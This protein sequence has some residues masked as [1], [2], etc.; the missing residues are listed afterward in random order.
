MTTNNHAS[1]SAFERALNNFK[2]SLKPKYQT[3][4]QHATVDS[5]KQCIGN[6]Q[7]IQH[8]SR[9]MQNLTRLQPFIEAMEQYG[10]V[11]TIFANTNAIIAYVWVASVMVEAFEELLQTY[12][13]IGDLIPLLLQYEQLFRKHPHMVRILVLMYE[14]ILSFHHIALRYFQQPLWRQMFDATWKTHKSKF[15]GIFSNMSHHRGLIESQA[16]IA[17]IE[18]IQQ[19]RERDNDRLETQLLHEENQR[20]KAVYG[21]LNAANVDNDQYHF[22]QL[23]AEH[24]G[25]GR[26]LLDHPSFKDDWFNPQYPKV[27]PL[28]WL[29]GIPGAGKTVLASL[30]VEE[31]QKLSPAPTVAF[32]YCKHGN[33][34]RDNFLWMARSILAQLLKQHPVMLEYFFQKCC[35][36]PKPILDSLVLVEELLAFA[37]ENCSSAYVI[38][39]GLDECPRDERKHIVKWFRKL[40]EDPV[41]EPD[42]IRCLFISQDDGVARKD[43]GGLS[44]TKITTQDNRKDIEQYCR[45]KAEELKQT[46]VGLSDNKA[47][48]IADRVLSSTHGMFLFAKLV[49]LNLLSQT[50]LCGLEEE[51]DP[52]RFPEGINDA[53][54]RIVFRI[55]EQS[56]GPRLTDI[57]KLL[58]WLACAKRSLKWYEIQGMKAINVSKR[59]IDHEGR[60]FRVDPTDLCASLV[61]S[62]PDGSLEF[63]H[64]TAKFFLAE[65]GYVDVPKAELQIANLCIDYLNLPALVDDPN[66]EGVHNGDYGFV[67]YATLYWVRHLEAGLSHSKNDPDAIADLAESLEIFLD[68]HWT[69]RT[70]KIAIGK[71]NSDR[72]KVFAPYQFYKRLE[73]A[74]VSA[75]RQLTF[76]GK[77]RKEEIVLDL[78][79]VVGRVRKELEALIS[80]SLDQEVWTDLTLKYGS[81]L[82]KCPR[83][84]CQSFSSGFPTREERERHVAKHDLPFNC[85][86]RACPRF[87][88]G[89]AKKIECDKHVQEVHSAP[90]G[91]D[92]QFPTNDEVAESLQPPKAPEPIPEPASD[93][94]QDPEPDQTPQTVSIPP[95]SRKKPKTRE[96]RC[97]YCQKL[98]TK[99]WNLDSHR[100]THTKDRPYK[101]DVCPQDFPRKSDYRR[102]ML[103]H[104]ENQY[105]CGG[106]LRNGTPWGCGYSFPRADNLSNHYKSQTGKLCYAPYA[107]ELNSTPSRGLAE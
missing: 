59:V 60:R 63:V 76:F 14:D 41:N 69:G 39:D 101:C 20:F 72:L 26:W 21:W 46:L 25:T 96:L 44:N 78:V 91:D 27:P 30:V 9:R 70:V 34:E 6:I 50:D 104:T 97:E 102:H 61:E 87:I 36:D 52:H 75:R 22:F 7:N 33:P 65:R 82:F 4:F 3:S 13:R 79:D 37:F 80:P 94:V 105:K 51:L 17:H 19:Q 106:M 95:R 12:E 49:W 32:F 31:A 100:S 67:D 24:P 28:L 98:F 55:K 45:F 84:S 2:Q 83:M 57:F 38:L 53:Y 5:L 47:K 85:T 43:F 8:A 1:A 107:Q 103:T 89:F 93:V 66:E 35:G 18:E 77:L 81:N 68:E 58:S 54:E 64:L 62:R 15:G 40:V 71:R 10:K 11:I 86:E 23:R 90:L 88:I 99:K 56:P 16:S 74:T 29:S 73:E 48:D 92:Q 42:R